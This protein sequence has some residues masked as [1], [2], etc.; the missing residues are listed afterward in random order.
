MLQLVKD[1]FDETPDDILN[2]IQ[3]MLNNSDGEGP[4]SESKEEKQNK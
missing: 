1:D 4:K 2:S 3:K